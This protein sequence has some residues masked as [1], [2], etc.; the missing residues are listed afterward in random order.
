MS[1]GGGNDT[2]LHLPNG[3]F[4]ILR[5]DRLEDPEQLK[6]MLEPDN[7][8][9]A[10]PYWQKIAKKLGI[11]PDIRNDAFTRAMLQETLGLNKPAAA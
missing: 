6:L 11:L 9:R 4:T 10:L 5:E 7:F 8:A 2:V 1:T 3:D